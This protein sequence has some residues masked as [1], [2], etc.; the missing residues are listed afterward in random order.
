MGCELQAN[1]M[2]TLWV[3]TVQLSLRKGSFSQISCD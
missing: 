1:M 3:L 2:N